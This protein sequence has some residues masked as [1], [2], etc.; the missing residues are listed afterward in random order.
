[1]VLG[2]RA[3]TH[4]SLRELFDRALRDELDPQL[5]TFLDLDKELVQREIE[6]G[7]E[8]RRSGPHAENIL[9]DIGVVA[10]RPV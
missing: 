9:K 3:I 7:R 2:G 6:R 5:L 4:A 1:V 10:A 8:K